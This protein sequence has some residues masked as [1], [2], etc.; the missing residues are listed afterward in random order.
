[1]LSFRQFIELAEQNTVGYHND[2]PG[3]GFAQSGGGAMLGSDWTG[4]EQPEA[5]GMLGR[6]LSLPSYDMAVPKVK[7]QSRVK[8]L[9]RNNNP[10]LMILDDGTRMSFTYDE[11][12]RIEG[13][14]PQQ[15]SLITVVFQRHPRMGASAM[16]QIDSIRC[17]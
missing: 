12:K 17:D 2:G 1:M 7:R 5:H 8:V 13:R 16:S 6:P 14:E 9:E 15:G 10:I 3:S 11:F 4:S